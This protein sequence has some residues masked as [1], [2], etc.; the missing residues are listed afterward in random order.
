MTTTATDATAL[1][2][3]QLWAVLGEAFSFPTPALAK[4]IRSGALRATV[5]RVESALPY[6]LP[7]EHVALHDPSLD[8]RDL[9]SEFIRFFDAPSGSTPCPLYAGVYAANRRDAME[10]ILRFYRHF[11]LTSAG[12]RDLPDSVP[13]ICEFL[14]FLA[15]CESLA[16]DD[17]RTQLRAAQRDFLA[18][19]LSRWAD[20]TRAR[21]AG[22]EPLTFYRGLVDFAHAVVAAELAELSG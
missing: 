21:L 7:L 2:R 14:Q 13:T 8:E 5:A 10:E 20:R 15:Y 4:G 17:G 12:S 6:R 9:Q 19:H 18:R 1:A 11:G 3:S 22:R 16:T